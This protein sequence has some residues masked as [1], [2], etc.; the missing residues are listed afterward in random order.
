MYV[1]VCVRAGGCR[2]PRTWLEWADKKGKLRLMCG[3]YTLEDGKTLEYYH[4]KEGS[5]IH[6]LYERYACVCMKECA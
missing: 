5:V 3:A 1:R 2:R 4:I 6:P